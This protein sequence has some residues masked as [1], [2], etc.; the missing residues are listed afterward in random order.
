M[1]TAITIIIIFIVVAVVIFLYNYD[2]YRYFLSLKQIS[3]EKI[4]ELKR[5]EAD[6]HHKSVSSIMKDGTIFGLVK[7]WWQSSTDDCEKRKITALSNDG[8]I[9][10]CCDVL[11]Y[12]YPRGAADIALSYLNN[13]GEWVKVVFQI[14]KV[15]WGS[16]DGWLDTII[17]KIDYK[18]KSYSYSDYKDNSSIR[19]KIAY[20]KEI[21]DWNW[22]EPSRPE[23]EN[24]PVQLE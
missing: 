1:G 12:F 2:D 5:K 22:K 13:E 14:K 18:G 21:L 10:A 6:S 17:D 8:R 19:E 16:K 11:A 15:Y 24:L 4:N 9:V 7:E 20:W 3:A 23:K